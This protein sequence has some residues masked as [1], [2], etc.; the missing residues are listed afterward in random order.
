MIGQEQLQKF[1][2]EMGKVRKDPFQVVLRQ[3]RLPISLLQEK[4][5]VSDIHLTLHSIVI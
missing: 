3:T 2:E 5:D 4:A 1:Q